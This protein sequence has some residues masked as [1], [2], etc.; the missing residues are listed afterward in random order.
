MPAMVKS[1]LIVP[2]WDDG[3]ASSP[4]SHK[5]MVKNRP[6]ASGDFPLRFLDKVDV[7]LAAQNTEF[8]ELRSA[9]G[10]SRMGK[11]NKCSLDGRNEWLVFK[12][13][14]QDREITAKRASA[15]V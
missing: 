5:E 8:Y 13:A 1:R 11:S 15:L 7:G 2:K 3:R 10:R 4:S 9:V 6:S 14:D 12:G